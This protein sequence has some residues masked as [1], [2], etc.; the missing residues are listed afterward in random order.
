MMDGKTAAATI[1]EQKSEKKSTKDRICQLRR[2][3]KNV[4][5]QKE[6]GLIKTARCSS[7]IW[8]SLGAVWKSTDK[9]DDWHIMNS[10]RTRPIPFA[11][12]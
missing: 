5:K 4:D 9:S 7:L 3:N 10:A 6:V 2:G 8:E 1:T 12:F 11:I